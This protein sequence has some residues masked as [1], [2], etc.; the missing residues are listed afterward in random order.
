M[1]DWLKYRYNTNQPN[2]HVGKDAP[3]RRQR[4]QSNIGYFFGHYLRDPLN[5]A[6]R[7]LWRKT[8]VDQGVFDDGLRFKYGRWAVRYH[9]FA[10]MEKHGFIAR[11]ES[12]GPDDYRMPDS[13]MVDGWLLLFGEGIV[14]PSSLQDSGVGELASTRVR[15][16]PE[17]T[18][19]QWDECDGK[20]V[21][22]P[23]FSARYVGLW[24]ATNPWRKRIRVCGVGLCVKPINRLRELAAYL[25]CGGKRKCRVGWVG[26]LLNWLEDK[27]AATELILYAAAHT[28]PDG[29]DP[30]RD[31]ARWRKEYGG[32]PTAK[33]KKID[34]KWIRDDV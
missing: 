30:T 26:D 11:G 13:C 2:S 16:L 27:P 25:A 10:D 6:F 19:Q 8:L 1:D 23:G 18:Q 5:E 12:M 28:I 32:R 3:T 7:A 20:F 14:E 22:L 29:Y 34:G 24:V 17:P 21:N 31:P 15:I 4:I 9:S 33:P